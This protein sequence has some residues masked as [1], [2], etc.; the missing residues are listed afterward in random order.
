MNKLINKVIN[1]K[2]RKDI[3]QRLVGKIGEKK[4]RLIDT[5]AVCVVWAKNPL[6]T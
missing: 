1:W 5:E 3:D 6:E 2:K 4:D